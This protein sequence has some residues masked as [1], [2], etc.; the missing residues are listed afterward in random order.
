MDNMHNQRLLGRH[1]VVDDDTKLHKEE[2]VRT[3]VGSQIN[4]IKS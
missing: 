4:Q 1:I 3:D 2:K